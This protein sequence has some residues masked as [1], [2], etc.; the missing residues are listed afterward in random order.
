MWRLR[1]NAEDWLPKIIRFKMR[2][3]V[4]QLK[5]GQLQKKQLER[6]DNWHLKK[7]RFPLNRMGRAPV[8]ATRW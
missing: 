5:R 3:K 1:R 6:E 8:T 7:P 4:R 2:Q